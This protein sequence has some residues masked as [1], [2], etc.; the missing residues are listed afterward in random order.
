MSWPAKGS[1]NFLKL[2]TSMTMK[3]LFHM[4]KMGM[5]SFTKFDHLSKLWTKN[6]KKKHLNCQSI[7]ESMI[8]FKGRNTMKQYMPKKPVKRGYKVWVRADPVTGYMSQFEVYT[9]KPSQ[10]EDFASDT[11]GSRVVKNLCQGINC[12]EYDVLL[13]VVFDNFFTSY[14]LMVFL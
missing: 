11:L 5:I 7:D 6:F 2:F 9:G 14:D 1:R 13:L 12:D 3:Q 4:A 10:N 8:K